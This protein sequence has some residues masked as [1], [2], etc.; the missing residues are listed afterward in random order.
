[1]VCP[2]FSSNQFNNTSPRVSSVTKL[3]VLAR[4]VHQRLLNSGP[5]TV[6]KASVEVKWPYQFKN[7]SLLYITS[8]EDRGAD[9]LQ[10]RT[11]RSTRSTSLTRCPRRRTTPFHPESERPEGRKPKPRPQEKR[12]GVKR[13]TE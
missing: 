5:S 8:Y 9:Q 13:R 11:P 4:S 7:G 1:H 12:P 6:S 3:A 10:P 2:C